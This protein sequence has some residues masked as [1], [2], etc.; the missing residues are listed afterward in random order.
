MKAVVSLSGGMDSS[1]VLA[2]CIAQG[3]EVVQAVGFYYG[4]KH[5]PYE[6]EA[7]ER[8]AN[9]FHVPFELMDISNIM[10]KFTS[11]LLLT[12]GDIPEGHYHEA[13]MTQTVVPGRNLIFISILMGLAWSKEAE[14]VWLGIHSGDHFIYPDC[15]ENFFEAMNIA[16][17]TGSDGKVLLKAPFMRGNKTTIIKRG[18]ELGVPY[19]M[20]RT[21][22]K[23]QEIACGRCGS[24]QERLEAMKDN[25]IEDPLEYVVR[26]LLPKTPSDKKVQSTLPL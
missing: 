16:V 23:D 20:T 6:N 19:G 15:R 4:S 25:G 5:N 10:E 17:F 3:R 14:E 24:C 26:D 22:Y 11:N 1:T 2:E 12:G 7:A 21:C 13:N 8:I 18:L 9:H